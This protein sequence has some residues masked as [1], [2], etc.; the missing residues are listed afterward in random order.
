MEASQSRDAVA[1]ALALDDKPFR[2]KNPIRIKRCRI[3]GSEDNK[4]SKL[5]IP[6]KKKQPKV[7]AVKPE[8]KKQQQKTSSS[9]HVEGI[10]ATKD[11]AAKFNAGKKRSS[12]NKAKH[13]K[14]QK[15]A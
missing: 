3:P 12:K 8:K 2:G 5:T 13:N 11:L 10:R 14:K 9:N 4:N 7:E 15:R 6:N 1:L